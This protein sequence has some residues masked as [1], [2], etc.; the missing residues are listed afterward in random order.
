MSMMRTWAC[1]VEFE[2]TAGT[3]NREA[4]STLTKRSV[5][6]RP[7]L[8]GYVFGKKIEAKDYRDAVLAADGEL[9]TVLAPYRVAFDV[10]SCQ[11]VKMNDESALERPSERAQG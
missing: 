10:V 5:R 3:L 7:K 9:S 2:L 4:E 1:S 8:G 11:V 6:R